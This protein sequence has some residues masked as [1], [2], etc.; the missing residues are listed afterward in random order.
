MRSHVACKVALADD[1]FGMVKLW[2]NNWTVSQMRLALVFEMKM[3]W[4]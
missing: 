1:N 4:Q 2:G 3:E